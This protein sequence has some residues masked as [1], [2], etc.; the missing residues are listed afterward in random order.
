M[1]G[2]TMN[3]LVTVVVL[4]HVPLMVIG[5]E[6]TTRAGESLCYNC[7]YMEKSDG[8]M[9]KIPDMYED[10]PFCG[11]NFLNDTM[12]APTKPLPMIVRDEN[13]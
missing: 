2:K 6:T 3:C 1:I 4:F 8:T 5:D 10:I 13:K 7:G 12:D 11:D 9:V